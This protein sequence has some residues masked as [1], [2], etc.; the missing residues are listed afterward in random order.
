MTLLVGRSSPPFTRWSEDAQMHSFVTLLRWLAALQIISACRRLYRSL[1][2]IRY[3]SAQTLSGV[4]TK[5]SVVSRVTPSSP[6]SRRRSFK[7]SRSFCK[8]QYPG[9]TQA[10]LQWIDRFVDD[11]RG[12]RNRE[13][14]DRS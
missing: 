11:G 4:S 6:V 10:E 9:Y 5:K 8:S 2:R 13:L 3:D 14:L 7:G 1:M 12:K